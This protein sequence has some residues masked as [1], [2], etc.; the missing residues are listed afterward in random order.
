MLWTWCE[1]K[2]LCQ[3]HR[4]GATVCGLGSSS[5]DL[6]LAQQSFVSLTDGYQEK[7]SPEQRD[8]NIKRTL[9]SAVSF[10]VSDSATKGVVAVAVVTPGVVVHHCDN[11]AFHENQALLNSGQLK[12]ILNCYSEQVVQPF[13]CFHSNLTLALNLIVCPIMPV[14]SETSLQLLG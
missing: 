11:V 1:R 8:H 12:A 6:E 9:I 2:Q 4:V 14:T 7:I 5:V 13:H 10:G 3:A